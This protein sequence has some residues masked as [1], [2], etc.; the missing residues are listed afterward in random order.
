MLGF[1]NFIPLLV[2]VLLTACGG[3]GGGSTSNPDSGG[4]SSSSSSASSSGGSGNY[5]AVVTFPVAQSNVGGSATSIHIRG[6][7]TRDGEKELDDSSDISV[8]VNNIAADFVDDGTGNWIVEVPLQLGMNTFDVEVRQGDELEFSESS[9]VDNSPVMRPDLAVSDGASSTYGIDMGGV[10]VLQT[11][12]TGGE[13]ETLARVS[14]I[15]GCQKFQTLFLSGDADKLAVTCSSGTEENDRVVLFDLSDDTVKS[16]ALGFQLSLNGSVD[17]VTDTHLLFNQHAA[18]ASSFSLL[19]VSDGSITEF[20]VAF[21]EENGGS[22]IADKLFIDGLR[23]YVDASSSSSDATI[24]WTYFDLDAVIDT[25][26][27]VGTLVA[28]ESGSVFSSVDDIVAVDG[29]AYYL[30]LSSLVLWDLNTGNT[31]EIPLSAT[32]AD[33]YQSGIF[34]I[35][36]HDESRLV[37]RYSGTSQ[38]FSVALSSGVT[39]PITESPKLW[40]ATNL[41]V[42]PDSSELFS[43]SFANYRTNRIE[44]GSH[45]LSETDNLAGL[46]YID[47]MYENIRYDWENQAMYRNHVLSWSGVTPSDDP[48]VLKYNFSSG[49]DLPVLTSN[50]LADYFGYGNARY[51]VDD[52]SFGENE[53]TLL[54]AAAIFLADSS[55]IKGVFTLDMQTREIAPLINEPHANSTIDPPYLSDFYPQ[56]NGVFL[57]EWRGGYLKILEVD[58]NVTELVAAHS[59]YLTTRTATFDSQRNLIYFDGYREGA[60]EGQ[61]DFTT[62]EVVEYNLSSDQQRMVASNSVGQGLPFA[63]FHHEYNQNQQVLYSTLYGG[64]LIVDA[65]SG[66]RVLKMFE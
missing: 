36:Y 57:V 55:S 29:K 9:S 51:R 27:A 3:G 19:N 62:V 15:A 26:E 5:R 39:T 47:T 66:D 49:N 13:V 17:W 38:L 33:A 14:E 61:A 48:L 18:P 45:T 53:N 10:Y 11:A 37:A 1:K 58:G 31:S 32:V 8:T 50:D 54:F 35:V 63:W 41:S 30:D 24:I 56:V 28:T 52:V 22:I 2:T 60:T 46:Y 6:Y 42:N 16:F 7:V 21:N 65:Y 43:Y 64:L 40:G 20:N 34:T 4:S 44:L 23:V 25:P 12:I 59:P